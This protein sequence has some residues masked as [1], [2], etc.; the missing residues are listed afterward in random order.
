M[1]SA[2]RLDHDVTVVHW[3]AERA[4]IEQLRADGRP[5]LLL[6]AVT[7]AP[8]LFPD[9]LEDWVRVPAA[10]GEVAHRSAR[11]ARLAHERQAAHLPL[12]ADLVTRTE[13]EVPHG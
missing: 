6:V 5:R 1:P 13:S 12:S 8:P 7:A 11:L 10:D 2:P 4:R 9:E 3:P